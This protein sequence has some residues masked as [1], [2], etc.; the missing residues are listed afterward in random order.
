MVKWLVSRNIISSWSEGGFLTTD[1][2]VGGQIADQGL[3]HLGGLEVE[4]FQ[5]F[6]ERQLGDGHLVF[7]GPCLF[8]SDLGGQQVADDLLGLPND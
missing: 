7:D 2:K 1:I 5:F 6:G 4:L 3:V 8:L